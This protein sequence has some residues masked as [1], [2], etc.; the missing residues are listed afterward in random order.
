M[1][2]TDAGRVKVLHFGL[3]LGSIQYEMATGRRPFHGDSSPALMSSI[4]RTRRPRSVTSGP[5]LAFTRAGWC[6]SRI[7]PPEPG[8]GAHR[9]YTSSLRSEEVGERNVVAE[10][11]EVLYLMDEDAV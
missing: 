1:M 2:V 8:G 10:R 7:P 9:A 4:L 3:A 11:R 6:E 5:N